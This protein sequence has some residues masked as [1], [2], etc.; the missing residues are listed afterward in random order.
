VEAEQV[1]GRYACFTWMQ[2]DVGVHGNKVAITEHVFNGELLVR[3]IVINKRTL[4]LNGLGGC[5]VF[6]FFITRLICLY[7]YF[8]SGW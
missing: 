6:L 4:P 8:L 7:S 1:H 5:S 2:H 3:N